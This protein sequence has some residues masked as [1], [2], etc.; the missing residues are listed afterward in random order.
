[1]VNILD[2]INK[3]YRTVVSLKYDVKEILIK[4]DRVENKA[5]DNEAR[6]IMTQELR[7]N[8]QEDAILWNFPITSLD[9]VALFEEKLLDRSFRLKM[10]VIFLINFYYFINKYLHSFVIN[11]FVLGKRS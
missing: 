3:L 5:T 4:L 9:E 1:M 2:L 11:C 7:G 6:L 8:E 10:V